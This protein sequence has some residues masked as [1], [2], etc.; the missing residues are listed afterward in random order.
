MQGTL[1][2]EARHDVDVIA[3]PEGLQ[4]TLA[5]AIRRVHDSVRF[6][7]VGM[8]DVIVPIAQAAASAGYDVLLRHNGL[9][10]YAAFC[11]DFVVVTKRKGTL[12]CVVLSDEA[13]SQHRQ[14][15]SLAQAFAQRIVRFRNFCRLHSQRGVVLFVSPDKVVAQRVSDA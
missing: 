8:W 14:A 11:F 12:V 13:L 4:A 7:I 9:R 3:V 15:S 2:R 6:G 1:Q 5:N 10:D